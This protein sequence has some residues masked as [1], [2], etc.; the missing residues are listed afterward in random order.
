MALSCRRTNLHS[1]QPSVGE[2][3]EKPQ[4]ASHSP[5]ARPRKRG[6]KQLQHFHSQLSRRIFIHVKSSDEKQQRVE[7]GDRIGVSLDPRGL[8]SITILESSLRFLSRCHTAWN[9]L[10]DGVL[11]SLEP[12]RRFFKTTAQKTA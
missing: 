5:E 7:R 12:A 8:V 9:E 2:I 3:V 6:R 11:P 1:T 4:K 10:S